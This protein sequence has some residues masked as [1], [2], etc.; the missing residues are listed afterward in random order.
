MGDTIGGNFKKEI[1]TLNI[2]ENKKDS[3]CWK[4][5]GQGLFN[6]LRKLAAPSNIATFGWKLILNRI[7]TR[8][9]LKKR[10]VVLPG[11]QYLCPLCSLEEE[12]VQHL[13]FECNFAR[14]IW[15]KC[16]K[17]EGVVMVQPQHSGATTTFFV[18]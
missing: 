13:F 3:W 7:Q 5:N 9:N 14:A 6:G 10:N 16:Y 1:N 15:A 8:S 4:S 12:T 2:K 18:T 11:D 17:W